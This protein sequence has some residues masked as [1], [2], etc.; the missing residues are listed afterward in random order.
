[1]STEL[2]PQA[3]HRCCDPSTVPF[4]STAQHAATL[5]IVGQDRAVEALRFAIGMRRAGYNVFALGPPGLGKVTLVQQLLGQDASRRPVP[6]DWIYVVDFAR[7]DQ[8]TALELPAGGAIEVRR[9][10]QQVIAEVRAVRARA[11]VDREHAERT[12]HEIL[13]RLRTSFHEWPEVLDRLEAVEAD[14][15]DMLGHLAVDHLDERLRRHEIGVMVEHGASSAGPI[16]IEG[17]PTYAN[18]F[19]RIDHAVEHGVLVSNVTL[20]RPGALHRANGGYLLIDAFKLLQQPLAWEALERA[21]RTRELRIEPSVGPVP[22]GTLEPRPIPLDVKVILFADRSVYSTLTTL[23]PELGDL[24]KVVVDFAATMDRSPDSVLA[25]AGLIAALVQRESLA[26]FDRG[27]VARVIEHG[28]RL[29]GD[30]EKLS[31]HLRSITDLLCEASDHA[32]RDRREVVTA[33]DVTG[34]LAAARRRLGHFQDVVLEAIRR[35]TLVI[36]TRG[37]AVGQVNG[38]TVVD[39]DPPVFAHPARITATVQ[40]GAGEVIDIEREVELGGPVHSKGVMILA[41]LIGARYATHAPLHLTARIVF[42][43]SYNEIE[44]DSA[45]LAEICALISAIGDVPVLQ[46][47]A[48]TGS[49]NQRGEVQPVGAINEKIEGFFDACREHGLTG[50]QGVVIPKLNVPQLML[51]DDVV[52]AVAEG[53]FHVHAVHDVDEALAL[54]TNRTVAEV[55]AS[56]EARLR[57]FAEDVRRIAGGPAHDKWRHAG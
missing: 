14:V 7:P 52:T 38:L 25:Y 21:L 53:R 20:I 29:T 35:H 39:A 18:L 28:A 45:T 49:V 16:V 32:T 11:G 2:S 40:L 34:A 44:G 31:L 30:A 22:M 13:T 37:A 15:L 33:A 56:V 19:G 5:A 43:Q 51:R 12:I 36:E 24:F 6:S 26:P 55:N 46:Q 50:D 10:I 27:A 17:H 57:S 3:L 4:D 47:F 48:I 1:M 54:L 42:E 8:P 9:A 41:G 23:E